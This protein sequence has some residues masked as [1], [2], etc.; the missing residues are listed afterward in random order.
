[1]AID[2]LDKG[3]GVPVGAVAEKLHVK[4]TFVTTETMHLELSGHVRR[5]PSATD[6][7]VVLLSL[8][9]KTVKTINGFADQRQKVNDAIF[10]SFTAGEF[11]IF[12]RQI[13]GIRRELESAT[14][15]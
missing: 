4:P 11:R 3:Q 8:T 9:D 14:H 12:V 15:R 1:M 2:Y 7:R 6:R 10:G 13:E 5:V